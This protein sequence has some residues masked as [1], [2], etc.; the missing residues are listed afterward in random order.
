MKIDKQSDATARTTIGTVLALFAAATPAAEMC[1]VQSAPDAAIDAS[2]KHFV[3]NPDGQT[4]LSGAVQVQQGSNRLRAERVDYDAQSGNLTARGNVRYTNCDTREPTWFLSADRFTLD[5]KRGIGTARNAWLVVGDTPLLYLPRYRVSLEG[6]RHSG[7]LAPDISNRSK[8]GL[9]FDLPYYFNIAPNHDATFGPRLLS[10]RGVQFNGRYRYLTRRSEGKLKGDWLDDNDYDSGDRYSYSLNHH[11]RSGDNL[12][13]ALQLQ[14]VSDK[15]YIEDLSGSFDLI[16]ENYLNSQI[17]ADYVW[18]GWHL[19]FVAENFQR[20]DENTGHR[21]DLYEK[22]PGVALSKNWYSPHL[23]LNLDLKSEWVGFNRKKYSPQSFAGQAGQTDGDRFDNELTLR[24]SY[25]R[26]GFHFTPSAGIRH[27]DYQLDDRPDE[28]RTL[29]WF[30]LRTGLE[31]EKSIRK[32]RYRRTFEPELFYLHVPQRNQTDFPVFDT[33]LSEFRFSQLFEHNRYNGSDRVGDADQLTLALSNRLIHSPSGK[34]ALRLSI[35]HTSYFRNRNVSL[36][37]E[38]N[39]TSRYDYSDLASELALNF[40]GKARL[41]SF[42]IWD[43]EKKLPRRYANRLSLN[44]GDNKIINLS[45][46]YRRGDEG[47]NQSEISFSLPS[48]TR[49]NWFGGWRHDLDSG[50]SIGAMAGFRYDS[51]CWSLSLTGQR[52]LENIDGPDPSIAEGSLDYNTA[53]G[54]EFSLRGLS[55]FGTNTGDRLL[56]KWITDYRP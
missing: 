24:W 21:S 11:T 41:T 29:P 46:R 19:N 54:I 5:R 16:S 27:T 43:T 56:E 13:V 52:L 50:K 37:D 39:T 26:P 23:N 44:A 35:G 1:P 3:A 51:C 31:F 25:R 7:L 12:R 8:T 42:L 14:R 30:S 34:E 49:W 53:I 47:F 45:H 33:G 2:A 10:K 32:G 40:N 22:Q 4:R 20:I 18:R 48:G 6:K 17:L 15:D 28:S 36:P 9:E 38:D 55:S